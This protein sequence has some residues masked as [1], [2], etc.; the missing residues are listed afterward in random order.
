MKKRHSLLEKRFLLP[1]GLHRRTRDVRAC[2]AFRARGRPA[3]VSHDT[4]ATSMRAPR[5]RERG[6]PRLGRVRPVRRRRVRAPLDVETE[7]KIIDRSG[8][9]EPGR[10]TELEALF[11]RH[12]RL[13]ASFEV[14]RE[15]ADPWR[16]PES[17]A[18]TLRERVVARREP[19][20]DAESETR[21]E[22]ESDSKKFRKTREPPIRRRARN[23]SETTFAGRGD[24][25][26]GRE[27]R[28]RGSRGRAPETRRRASEGLVRPEERPPRRA[29]RR[30]ANVGG[31]GEARR[32]D[33][34]AHR[35]RRRRPPAAD[36]RRVGGSERAARVP[37]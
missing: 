25:G 36:A 20:T 26:G 4:R 17:D 8:A 1:P 32:R 27:R 2:G 14:C 31:D 23:V 28:A 33:H 7:N 5:A 29:R 3:G 22:R 10:A 9:R 13:D 35:R 11:F 18:T 34:R 12:R 16:E 15:A 6:P 37:R 30:N 19:R 21:N 24:R